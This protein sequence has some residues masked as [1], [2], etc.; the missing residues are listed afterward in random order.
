MNTGQPRLRCLGVG[1]GWPCADRG[2]SSFLYDWGDA[3]WLCDCGEPTAR[4]LKAAGVSLASI[5][6]IL[7]SHLH[8]DH[9]GGLF[10][11]VQSCW[12]EQ[13]KR[14]LTIR[15]PAHGIGAVREMLR[16]GF[17]FDELFPFRL[18]WRAWEE[19]S[20]VELG[21]VRVAVHRTTHLDGL[22]QRF[23]GRM[24]TGAVAYGFTLEDGEKRVVHSADLGRPEDLATTLRQ[25]AD[26]LLCELAHFTPEDLFEFLRDRPVRRLLLVHLSIEYWRDRGAI[27]AAAR[28]ALPNIQVEIPEDGFEAIL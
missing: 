24:P 1:P 21:N 22:L 16:Q 5:D 9:I 3:R 15:L 25:P 27:L 6:E 4:N 20:T 13:R 17:I 12:V 14:P 28:K 26:L 2:G 11:F 19:G 10:M 7:I 8:F 23:P 18:N